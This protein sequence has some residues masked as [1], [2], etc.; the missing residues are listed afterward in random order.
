ML[1]DVGQVLGELC[2][3]DEDGVLPNVMNAVLDALRPAG[4]THLDMP[5]SAQR[6]WAALA[7]SAGV[8]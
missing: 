2:S 6:V 4:V 7:R 1:Q 3:Y 8:P 5:A